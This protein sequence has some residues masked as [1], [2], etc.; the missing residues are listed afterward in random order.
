LRKQG[1]GIMTECCRFV[2]R[3]GFRT[4]DLNR[5]QIPAATGNLRSRRIP[6]RLGFKLE[7]ILRERESLNGA[8]VD[9]AMYSLLRRELPDDF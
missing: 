6:E 7:G 9:H 2:V 4:L 1:K 5:I 8:F 3:Y